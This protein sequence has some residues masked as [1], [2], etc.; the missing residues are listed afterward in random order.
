MGIPRSSHSKTKKMVHPGFEERRNKW[1]DMHTCHE[2][3][4]PYDEACHMKCPKPWRAIE[5]TCDEVNALKTCHKA[6]GYDFICH[7]R[8]PMPTCAHAKH[9]MQQALD[10]HGQCFTMRGGRS[11]HTA[12]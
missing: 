7:K 3:C 4:Q 11:C 2:K 6:C 10:C 9:R 8:C 1:Q 5:N 12:C